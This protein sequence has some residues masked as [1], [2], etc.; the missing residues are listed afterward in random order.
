MKNKLNKIINKIKLDYEIDS[1]CLELLEEYN[2][3]GLIGD[4][5]DLADFFHNYITDEDEIM[6]GH[7]SLLAKIEDK[8][9]IIKQLKKNDLITIY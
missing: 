2:S 4:S 1:P 5:I 6:L 9:F 7:I 3:N 8:D